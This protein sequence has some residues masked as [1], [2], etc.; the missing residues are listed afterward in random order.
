MG[1][2]RV[3]AL[4][5]Q[6]HGNQPEDTRECPPAS[7]GAKSVRVQLDV[8]DPRRDEIRKTVF[9]VQR[10][11]ASNLAG[12]FLTKGAKKGTLRMVATD[13]HR[14]ALIDRNPPAARSPRVVFSRA[15]AR[16][17]GVSCLPEEAVP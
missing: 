14:L 7:N 2:G 13:R 10:R 3:R 4:E 15:R 6:A 9:A 5:L 1:R 12:I 11:H 16:R 8:G 17:L